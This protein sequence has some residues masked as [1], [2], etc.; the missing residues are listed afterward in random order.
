MADSKFEPLRIKNGMGC[1]YLSLG[2]VELPTCA[3]KVSRIST[4]QPNQVA[5][6]EGAKGAAT[7]TPVPLGQ[8]ICFISDDQ[9]GHEFCGDT[10]KSLDLKYLHE[11]DTVEF[12][13]N[14][15]RTDSITLEI[16]ES[17]FQRK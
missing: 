9:P 7:V 15:N 6:G 17:S 4:E 16:K 1:A 12:L 2:R 8:K 3:L 11:G 5:R 13:L 10:T 14:K